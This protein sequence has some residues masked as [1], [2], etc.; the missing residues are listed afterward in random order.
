MLFSSLSVVA[1]LLLWLAY[2]TVPALYQS[3]TYRAILLA[4]EVYSMG[5]VSMVCF[6]FYNFSF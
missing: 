6:H 4:K 1:S 3:S 5:Q 2:Y